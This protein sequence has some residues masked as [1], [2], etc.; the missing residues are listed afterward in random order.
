MMMMMGNGQPGS[1]PIQFLPQPMPPPPPGTHL[2]QH[3]PFV[4]QHKQLNMIYAPYQPSQMPHHHQQQFFNMMQP[5]QQQPLPPISP[6]MM[7][8]NINMQ[9][10][11]PTNANVKNST[12]SSFTNKKK[13]CYNCGSMNHAA[14]ECK[15]PTIELALV[16]QPA[17]QQFKLNYKPN[18][19]SNNSGNTISN[20][21][22]E[23]E[24]NIPLPAVTLTTTN[25]NL[26]MPTN[27]APSPSKNVSNRTNGSKNN[28]I[29]QNNL[30]Q[31]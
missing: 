20:E 7:N 29:N 26:P 24:N 21:N 22:N 19:N 31:N 6:S 9:S 8:I 16:S 1:G 27:N 15:E 13:S 14:Y 12:Q 10:N 18:S 23:N 28:R 25:L 3:N 5:M 17:T 2:V 30:M 4:H 11:G